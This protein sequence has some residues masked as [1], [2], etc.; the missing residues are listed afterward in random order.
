MSK[1]CCEDCGCEG[2]WKN[3][4]VTPEG[5]CCPECNSLMISEVDEDEDEWNS[6]LWDD[7]EDGDDDNDDNEDDDDDLFDDDDY[8]DADDEDDDEEDF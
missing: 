6:V 3:L 7:E 2:D 5:L 8:D 4:L 1:F